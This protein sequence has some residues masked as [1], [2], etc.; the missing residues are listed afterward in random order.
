MDEPV[1]LQNSSFP[2]KNSLAFAAEV[3]P[4][5]RN[6][7]YVQGSCLGCVTFSGR[8]NVQRLEAVL[9]NAVV[10]ALQTA[11]VQELIERLCFQ[12]TLALCRSH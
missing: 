3:V 1:W 9:V 7:L 4:I 10:V 8:L 2:I 6:V 12:H 11:D 5:L